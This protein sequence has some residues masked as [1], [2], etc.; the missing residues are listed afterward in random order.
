MRAA[1]DKEKATLIGNASHLIHWEA[2]KYAKNKGIKEF[3]MG[4]LIAGEGNDYPG[5]S[6]DAFKESFGG[7]RVIRYTYQR[8]YTLSGKLYALG[9]GLRRLYR[10]L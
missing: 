2:M 10:S 6:R 5:H 4:G 1:A 9:Q 8:H 7:K 3:D